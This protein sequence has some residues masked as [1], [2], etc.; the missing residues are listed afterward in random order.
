MR[1]WFDKN[2]WDILNNV[3]ERRKVGGRESHQMTRCR[4]VEDKLLK[5]GLPAKVST[6]F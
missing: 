5:H 4:G 1:F 2:D 3:S 6:R